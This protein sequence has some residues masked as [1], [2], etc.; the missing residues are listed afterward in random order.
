MMISK[1]IRVTAFIFM[2]AVFLTVGATGS[3]YAATDTLHEGFDNIDAT[4]GPVTVT[5]TI[6][7]GEAFNW[8]SPPGGKAVIRESGVDGGN[9][10]QMNNNS[11]FT[12]GAIAGAIDATSYKYGK[13]SVYGVAEEGSTLSVV[14]SSS[15]GTV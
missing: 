14:L 6:W 11:I 9:R 1:K 10:A 12:T 4:G 5:D 15:G 8:T 3:A 13:L 7:A 2:T